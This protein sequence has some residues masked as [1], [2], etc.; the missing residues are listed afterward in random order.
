MAFTSSSGR[1]PSIPMSPTT[2]PGRCRWS[3]VTTGRSPQ[4]CSPSGQ[5]FTGITGTPT[6][7]NAG[8][9]GFFR[10][11]IDEA[12]LTELEASGPG[13]RTPT[14]R[15]GLVDDAWSLTVAGSLSA[16]DF[17]RLAR[18]LAG[19]DDLN[20]WQ[21]LATGLHGLDRLVEGTAADVLAAPSANSP[22]QPSPLSVSSRVPTTTTARSNSATLVRLLGT[23]GNDAEVIAAAQGAVDHAE[24]S[25]GAAALTVVAHHGGQAE[26]DT[27]RCLARCDRSRHRDPQPTSARRLPLGRTRRATSRR[28]RRRHRAHP[29]RPVPDRPCTRGS[30]GRPTGLG[31][32]HHQLG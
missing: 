21:A 26:Y 15:H 18:A 24:A 16:V 32:R 7:V 1:S 31:F 17:L 3:S 22:V 20:V 9:A 12:I 25:L 28:H 13:D 11:A 27:I 29:G 4:R 30:N 8:A 6:T 14:E 2:A 5:C 23:A 10:T 19:E